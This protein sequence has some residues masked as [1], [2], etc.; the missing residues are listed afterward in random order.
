MLGVLVLQL[1]N[2]NSCHRRPQHVWHGMAWHGPGCA[3]PKLS[4][5]CL[6]NS[7]ALHYYHRKQRTRLVFEFSLEPSAI[8][9]AIGSRGLLACQL[10]PMEHLCDE[11]IELIVYELDDPTALTL[12]SKRFLRVSQDPYVRAHYFLTRYGHMD[13]M[14]WALVARIYPVTSS[15]LP[16]IISTAQPSTSSRRFGFARCLFLSFR[17]SRKSPLR[18]LA[19][20]PWAKMR[21]T[22]LFSVFF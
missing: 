13:A 4:Q 9:V 1:H 5:A 18:Y 2:T 3:T 10:R 12:T 14:F 20:F 8:R 11:I 16:Y 22:G 19:K 17:T 6:H 7:L 21:M 15:K